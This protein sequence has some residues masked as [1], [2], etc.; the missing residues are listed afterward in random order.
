MKFPVCRKDCS[1]DCKGLVASRIR[2]RQWG[3]PEV[4]KKVTQYY[5]KHG[6]SKKNQKGGL[7]PGSSDEHSDLTFR[8]ST[9][10][11]REDG[12]IH[13]V[14]SHGN[15]NT[16]FRRSYGT[17]DLIGDPDGMRYINQEKDQPQRGGGFFDWFWNLFGMN[18]MTGGAYVYDPEK[19]ECPICKGVGPDVELGGNQIPI[20]EN[21][22]RAHINCIQLWYSTANTCPVCNTSVENF[23][24]YLRINPEKIVT[25]HIYDPSIY[26]PNPEILNNF[27]IE[28]ILR[29]NDY[30]EAYAMFNSEAGRAYI[31][32]ELDEITTQRDQDIY[33]GNEDEDSDLMHNSFIL[34]FLNSLNVA[35]A[36]FDVLANRRQQF[37]LTQYTGPIIDL[38]PNDT[39]LNIIM[40]LREHGYH[41]SFEFLENAANR[42]Q[43]QAMAWYMNSYNIDPLGQELLQLVRD[44]QEDQRNRS[45]EVIM[46]YIN[47]TIQRPERRL[48]R[49]NAM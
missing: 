28:N 31:T 19:D 20:C 1:V 15:E 45:V 3:Y 18:N 41:A 9:G 38:Y 46:N 14:V 39:H 22:H 8:R 10:R 26:E 2:A 23:T 13:H 33:F 17:R 48:V 24:L 5:K 34:R 36:I 47:N 27:N 11:L 4:D 29:N 16:G 37:L 6:C 40:W 21:G 44:L 35:S 32:Q 49:Y 25:R 7:I 42:E 12:S 30:R 43:L